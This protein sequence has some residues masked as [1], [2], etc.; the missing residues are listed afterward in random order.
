M[1]QECNFIK[2]IKFQ[3]KNR[4]LVMARVSD[5]S[6]HKEWITPKKYLNFDLFL[7]YFGDGSNNFIDDCDFY[8]EA[9]D[10]K[11]PRLYQVINEYKDEIFKYDAVWIPD[12]DISTNSKTI[13]KLFKTFMKYKLQLAQPALTKDSYYSHKLTLSQSKYCLRYTHFVEVMVPMFSKDGLEKCWESFKMSKSGWG[14]D[15]IWPKLLGYPHK[16]IAI[17]D[18]YPVKHT[19]RVGKGTLYK[20]IGCSP[21][22]ELDRI[23]KEHGLEQQFDYKQYGSIRRK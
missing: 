2:P 20:N 4:L 10:T 19:R 17:I 15:S 22:E 9:K 14:L 18:K 21:Y 5:K 6:L 1:G 3:G 11:W 13:Q 8:S 12:D 16:Q 7:E 23:C